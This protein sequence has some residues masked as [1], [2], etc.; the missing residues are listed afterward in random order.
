MLKHST[1]I[2]K[3]FIQAKLNKIIFYSK[4][5][6]QFLTYKKFSGLFSFVINIKCQYKKLKDKNKSMIIKIILSD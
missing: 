1:F 5:I 6:I 4:L 3:C 2:N